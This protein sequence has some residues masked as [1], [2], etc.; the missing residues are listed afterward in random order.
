MPRGVAFVSHK[1]HRPPAPKKAFPASF[2]SCSSSSFFRFLSENNERTRIASIPPSTTTAGKN[3]IKSK[4]FQLKNFFLCRAHCCCS[5]LSLRGLKLCREAKLGEERNAKS[6][7]EMRSLMWAHCSN[8]C[9]TTDQ[10][11][12]LIISIHSP[13]IPGRD[14]KFSLGERG[15]GG[16]K[17]EAG[18]DYAWDEAL[19]HLKTR[20]ERWMQVNWV[21][22]LSLVIKM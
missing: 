9:E 3:E 4:T 19:V 18:G 6:R 15:N 10:F 21:N 17:E 1:F 13:Y 8:E 2:T 22:L 12:I 5:L 20:M 11:L 16:R 14:E 7:I